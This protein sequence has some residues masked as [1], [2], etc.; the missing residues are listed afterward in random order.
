VDAVSDVTF[1]GFAERI[2]A[3]AAAEHL[4]GGIVALVEHGTVRWHHAFGETRIGTGQRP[5]PDSVFRIASMTKS[6]TAA[7][8]LLLRDRALLRLDDPIATYLPWTVTIG[9]PPDGPPIAIR[10][11][12][13]MNGGLPTDDPWGDRHES[14]AL[15]DFDTLTADGFRFAREP[16]TGFEYSNLGYALLG[17]I[18]DVVAGVPYRDVV[19]R[20]LLAPLGLSSTRF[21][22]TAIDDARRA[23]GYALVDGSL[24]AEPLVA[25]GAFSPMGGLHSSVRD[26]ARWIDGFARP[27]ATPSHP[28]RAATRREQQEGR[29][30]A[31]TTIV[32]PN[33]DLPSRTITSLYAYGLVDDRDSRF[34]RIV[35]HSG[36][37]PG[38]GSHMRWHPA[39]GLG[40]VA[41]ANRTYAPMRDLASTLFDDAL[42]ALAPAPDVAPTLWPATRAALDIAERLLREWDDTLADASFA[43]NV[44]LDVPRAVRRAEAARLGADLGA[45]SRLTESLSSTSPAQA[46]WVVAGPSVRVRIGVLLSP[47]R[48]PRLQSLV[49][50]REPDPPADTQRA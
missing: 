28:L 14:L 40:I 15:D 29:S 17:R 34:G 48:E 9:A 42:A 6:F 16:R 38:F 18:V 49:Y 41:L 45:F 31:S 50:R 30:F 25:P 1:A 22:S 2:D 4:P 19:E 33:G 44:D 36:G 35:H 43:P 7:A 47:D 27:G 11:L 5:D 21:A 39:S 12:L 20:E 24:V 26:L 13:T 37:Y 8:I 23:H 10:D 46:E 3:V 32:A